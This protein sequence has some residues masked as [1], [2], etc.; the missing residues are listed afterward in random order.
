MN[1]NAHLP[2]RHNAT[3]P[4]RSDIQTEKKQQ[5]FQDLFY[6]NMTGGG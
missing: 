1:S 3:L 4:L 2:R 5:H 6:M